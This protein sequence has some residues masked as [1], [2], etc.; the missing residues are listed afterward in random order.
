MI[1]E[2]RMGKKTKSTKYIGMTGLQTVIILFLG[3]LSISLFAILFIL[4]ARGNSGIQ[5]QPQSQTPTLSPILTYINLST[6]QMTNNNVLVT[7]LTNLPDGTVIMVSINGL[8]LDYSAQDK[9][10][11]SSGKFRAGLFS[12]GGL[13]LNGGKYIAKALMPYPA[14]QPESV[15]KIIGNDGEKLAGDQVV[16]DNSVLVVATKNFEIIIPTPRRYL[17]QHRCPLLSRAHYLEAT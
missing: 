8:T 6:E 12:S 1:E 16:F 10:T 3:T 17:F 2:H 5:I 9:V 15:R 11:V 14:V 13:G 4:L 7:G